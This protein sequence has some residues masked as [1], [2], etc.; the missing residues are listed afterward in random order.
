MNILLTEII[1]KNVWVLNLYLTLPEL[2]RVFDVS[3][4][5]H[6]VLRAM[7]PPP[8]EAGDSMVILQNCFVSQLAAFLTWQKT[9]QGLVHSQRTRNSLFQAK[10]TCGNMLQNLLNMLCHKICKTRLIRFYVLYHCQT[11]NIEI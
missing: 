4:W 7:P 6:G 1:E 10:S 3:E 2:S 5:E 11:S 8:P 9:F